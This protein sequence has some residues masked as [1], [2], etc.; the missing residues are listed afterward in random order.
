MPFIC[1]HCKTVAYR[2]SSRPMS[3][4]TKEAHYRCENCGHG[5]KTIEQVTQT[6]SPSGMPNR[7]VHISLADSPA[8]LLE[9]NS[10]GV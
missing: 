10:D 9:G 4:Q 1:P 2:R 7:R 6:L 5:F 3:E 8:D